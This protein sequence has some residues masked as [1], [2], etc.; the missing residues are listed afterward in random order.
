MSEG[1]LFIEL[2]PQIA[3]MIVE[4]Q[5]MPPERYEQFKREYLEECEKYHPGALEFIK[6]VLLVIDTYLEELKEGE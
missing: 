2:I 6:N 1:E 5:K 3:E 4:V